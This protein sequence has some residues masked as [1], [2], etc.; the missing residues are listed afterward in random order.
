MRQILFI[1]ILFIQIVLLIS[2]E[3]GAK[4][5][6]LTVRRDYAPSES[7]EIELIYNSQIPVRL[8]LLRPK[9]MD[10]FIK[11]QIDLRRAW[12]EPQSQVNSARFFLMGLNRTRL[13]VD[14]IRYHFNEFI[15]SGL[16]PQLGGAEFAKSGTALSE[17]PS[18]MIRAPANFEVITEFSLAEEED[19]D[20]PFD[21]PGFNWYFGNSGSYKT[22]LIHLPA[23]KS[24]FYVVQ[25]LQG[26]DE[27]QVVLVVNDIKAMLQQTDGL[28]VIRAT[29]RTGAPLRDA[30]VRLRNLKGNWIQEGQTDAN[31]VCELKTDANTELVAV[32]ES[33][34]GTALI[35]TE[36][37]STNA[38]FP[39][40]FLYSDRPMYKPEGHVKFKGIARR[41]QDRSSNLLNI[42]GAVSTALY[43]SGGSLIAEGS[44]A[45]PT[46]FG[47]FSGEIP[48]AGARSSGI[49]RLQSSVNGI[50]HVGEIRVKEYVKPLYF[51]TVSS[52]LDSVR[53]GQNLPLTLAAERYAG[54]VPPSVVARVEILRVR[55]D[56]PEW[57]EDAGL[58]EKGS[59]TTYGFR[60]DEKIPIIPIS[61]HVVEDIRLPSSGKKT[62]SIPLPKDLPGDPGYDYKIVVKVS[63]TDA[64]ENFA[65]VSK[66]F[67]EATSEFMV[68][69][70]SSAVY[71]EKSQSAWLEARAL[72]PGGN[73]YG[74]ISGSVR[75]FV[76]GYGQEPVGHASQDLQSD[77]SGKFKIAFPTAQSG[78]V[79][80][81]LTLRSASGAIE[82]VS[83]EILVAEPGSPAPVKKVSDLT[84]LSRRSVYSEGETA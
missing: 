71:V 21:V 15:R 1:K 66:S 49:Y 68:Q 39:D 52:N 8:R 40:V 75:F 64:D 70:R 4:N 5:F 31:G 47:S 12:K 37:L 56:G 3:A 36:F 76:S 84:I 11:E 25:A 82:S 26:S 13:D 48:L 46:E 42:N 58:G 41:R 62:V 9:N 61:V 33:G 19:K 69:S 78:V 27:G 23:Q 28:A 30:K 51:L 45:Q 77:P 32:I 83:D 6:Y 80:A 73:P 59:E 53:P 79:T 10:G 54:G 22:R 63:A 18:R 7:P 65:S 17:G 67:L 57:I 43:A 72:T 81:T 24:G 74:K 34:E 44:T 38:E 50:A 20:K 14:W 55:Y 60:G 29:D 16:T 2:G 35:D